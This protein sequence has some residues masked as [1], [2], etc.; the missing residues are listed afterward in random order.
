MT[1]RRK[2]IPAL[3]VSNFGPTDNFGPTEDELTQRWTTQVR[4]IAS[5]DKQC[6]MAHRL[7]SFQ[8]TCVVGTSDTSWTALRISRVDQ[9][10]EDVSRADVSRQQSVQDSL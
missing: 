4:T 1:N 6:V 2:K 7:T 5:R 9:I 10:P 3:S 8:F